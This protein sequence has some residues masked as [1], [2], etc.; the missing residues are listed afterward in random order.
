MKGKEECRLSCRLKNLWKSVDTYLLIHVHVIICPYIPFMCYIL[1]DETLKTN[2]K[3]PVHVM[4][5]EF[6]IIAFFSAISL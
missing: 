1:E 5:T 3:I 2:K 4:Q 6:V